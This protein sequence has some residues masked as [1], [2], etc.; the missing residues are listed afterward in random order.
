MTICYNFGTHFLTTDTT[1][2]E[3]EL[4]NVINQWEV[5]AEVTQLIEDGA[6]IEVGEQDELIINYEA[7]E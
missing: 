7:I 1:L 4:A 3:E 6:V 2:S 5:N